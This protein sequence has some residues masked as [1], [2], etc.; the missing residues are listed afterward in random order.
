MNNDNL[1]FCEKIIT[2]EGLEQYNILKNYEEQ[3]KDKNDNKQLKIII[4]QNILNMLNIIYVEKN[5]L[6]SNNKA[7]FY[8]NII[9]K[10][11]LLFKI[12]NK[13]ELLENSFLTQNEINN[14]EK[15]CLNKLEK[16]LKKSIYDNKLND[17]S[18]TFLYLLTLLILKIDID[19]YCKQ[20]L[21]INDNNYSYFN[22]SF[23]NEINVKDTKENINK[24]KNLIFSLNKNNQ[25]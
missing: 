8:N 24:V 16:F 13:D 2:K 3:L 5:E 9:Y 7:L 23:N 1:E 17:I 20:N 6:K 14:I 10:L 22:I 11:R 19:N 4:I 18:V 21:T 12:T 25:E 15:Q